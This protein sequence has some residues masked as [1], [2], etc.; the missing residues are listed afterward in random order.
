MKQILQNLRNGETEIVDVPAPAKR[1][2][3]LSIRTKNTLVSVGTEKMLV[4]F[5]KGNLIQKAMQQ[6]DKVKQVINKVKTDGFVTTLHSVKNKLDTPLPL[7]YCNVGLVTEIGDNVE[8]FAIGDR[9]VSNGHH[10]EY[11]VVGKNLCSKIPPNVDDKTASFTVVAS[12]AL[13][14]IRLLQPSIGETYVVTG[15]GL[16]GLL[17]VQ[18]LRANGCNV[19]GIDYDQKRCEIAKGYGADVVPIS[20]GVSPVVYVDSLTNGI[21]VDGVLITASTQSNEP[22]SQAAKMC[23]KRGRVVLV[24]VVGLEL[25]RADFYEKEITFQVSCSYGPGR[26]DP[27]Y[28]VKGHDYPIAYVRWTELRNFEAILQLMSQGKINVESLISHTYSIDESSQAYTTISNSNVLGVILAYPRWDHA[29]LTKQVVNS[30]NVKKLRAE[31]KVNLGLIGSGNYATGILIPSFSKTGVY[32]KCVTGMGGVSSVHLGRKYGFEKISTDVEEIFEDGSINAVVIATRHD[33][34][35]RYILRALDAGMHI[36]VE[37]PLAITSAEL[38]ELEAK[39]TGGSQ[40]DSVLMV[41]YN[42]RFSPH[43]KKIKKLIASSKT[44]S[45]FIYTINAGHIES[46]HWTQNRAIGGGRIIGEVCHFVDLIRFLA[47]SPIK[48]VKAIFMDSQ[49]RDSV[50]IT[51]EFE[52]GSIGSINYLANGSK[53]LAKERLEIFNGGGILQLEN[54]TKTK[55]YGW[56]GF[57]RFKTLKQDKGQDACV[58]AFMDAIE[59]GNTDDLIEIDELIEI[60]RI[61]IEI[62]DQL[63]G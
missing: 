51:I 29:E 14:G 1:S 43:I 11:V 45:A 26:Y 40:S 38:N 30:P 36:F 60:A 57:T 52:S 31:K 6:P 35:A 21:G 27:E 41:G 17:A 25:S 34:H 53:S 4:E 23:R 63:L 44:P 49:N 10:A 19:I 46:G 33:S 58:R 54:F 47:G 61:C 16:I 9:V 24:G 8:G 20:Q 32:F 15:L 42:R 48:A 13:Q 28:E 5:G 39:L 18:I 50:M 62:E 7:G 22:I 59:S 12:I 2:G 3:H 56:P 55:G 37:K